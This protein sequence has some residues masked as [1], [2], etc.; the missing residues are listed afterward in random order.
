MR[1]SSRSAGLEAPCEAE[2]VRE[3][4][5][6]GVAAL[7]LTRRGR[8]DH[9]GHGA[10]VYCAR[11]RVL[12]VT[13]YF[14]P[15][16][17]APQSRLLDLAEALARRGHDVT[18]LTGFPNYPDGV[19]QPPYRIRPLQRERLRGLRIV[20]SAIYPAPNRGVGRRLVNH[21]SF[22]LSSLLAAP[23]AGRADV[24]LVETPPL[25]AAISGVAIAAGKRTPL[26]LNVADLWPDAAIQ[27]GALR[28]PG[29]IAA[30]RALERF[31]Y[32][33]ADAIAVPTPGLE[34]TLRERGYPSDRIVVAPHGVDPGR[35]P[36]DPEARPVPGR[37]V[38]CGTIGMGHAVGTLIDAARILDDDGDFELLLVGDGAERAELEERARGLRGVRFAGR[39]PRDELPALLASAEIAVAT[40]RDAP[41]LADALSTKVLEYMAAARP[42]VVA[43]SGWTADV[44]DRAG[45]G[46]VCPPEQPARARGGDHAPARRS[47]GARGHGPR[48]PPV[49]RG[50]PHPRRGGRP[51]RG[52]VRRGQSPT[53]TPCRKTCVP[54]PARGHRDPERQRDLVATPAPAQPPR[55]LARHAD[56]QG[57][58]AGVARDPHRVDRPAAAWSPGERLHDRPAHEPDRDRRDAAPGRDRAGP[59][60]GPAGRP[61]AARTSAARA[62]RPVSV[63][64]PL[65]RDPAVRERARVLVR[66]LVLHRDA[67]VR[68]VDR[69]RLRARGRRTGCPWS[70]TRPAAAPSRCRCRRAR[71]TTG[72]R[73]PPG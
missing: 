46:L 48:G 13:H 70:P 64:S 68:H 22:A 37:I 71:R 66:A 24:T 67:P 33:H 41:L 63:A 53:T 14:H 39:L 25:F 1:T 6:H 28:R 36:L 31:A 50:E 42:V 65:G 34:R 15:E 18:V 47:R 45:A 27:F 61:S 29:L 3:H 32:R 10:S 54:A 8:L 30:A 49:R 62:R 5:V 51:A 4:D 20:R 26:V 59:A 17:G 69:D 73:R 19:V 40:Q 23:A 43:A 56:R 12:F 9:E 57:V 16:V 35:F 72:R 52:R 7:R 2:P 55:V 60:G 11:V 21:L 58:G 44:V 38:Y